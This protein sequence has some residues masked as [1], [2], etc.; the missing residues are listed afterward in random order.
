M[1]SCLLR[2]YATPL[3]HQSGLKFHRGRGTDHRHC[4]EFEFFGRAGRAF[5]NQ[6]I[7]HFFAVEFPV[8]GKHNLDRTPAAIAPG[9]KRIPA[10]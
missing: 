5:E 1:L 8:A 10:S 4:I 7:G 9:E 3:H 2:H 6:L